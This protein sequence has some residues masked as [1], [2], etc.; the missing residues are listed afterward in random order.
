MVS[1]DPWDNLAQFSRLA[2]QLLPCLAVW[3]IG[4]AICLARWRR[5]PTVSL[6][7]LVALIL[8]GL[9]S[10][11][12]YTSFFWMPAHFDPG[13]MNFYLTMFG[14]LESS[15]NAIAFALLLIAVFGWRNPSTPT[16]VHQPDEAPRQADP[17]PKGIKR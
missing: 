2:L 17:V 9:S 6:L 11:V 4:A 5:H 7:A 8:F 12:V 1:N 15:I 16:H 10:I 13:E 14:L 3:L